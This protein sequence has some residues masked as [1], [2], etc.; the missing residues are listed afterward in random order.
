MAHFLGFNNSSIRKKELIRVRIM[1]FLLVSLLIIGLS[2][3]GLANPAFA[4][5]A[6][7]GEPVTRASIV[8]SKKHKYGTLTVP[9][10]GIYNNKIVR[11]RGTPDDGPG[12]VIQDKGITSAPYGAWGGVEVGQVGNF[13]LAG[14]R[15]SHGSLMRKV[16]KLKPGDKIIVNRGGENFTYIVAYKFVVNWKSKRSQ[17]SQLQPVPGK[18][19]V[20]A[21]R[22]AI[23]L[24]TC[25][26]PEDRAKGN[27]WRDKQGNPQHRMDVVGFLETKTP[28]IVG[29][30][31][32]TG[33]TTTSATLN[34]SVNPNAGSTDVKFTYST[35]PS[36]GAATSVTV[37]TNP[38]NLTGV[39]TR[40]VTASINGLLPATTYYVRVSASNS[41]GTKQ[42]EVITFATPA[43]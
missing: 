23:V 21:T 4:G 15:S 13:M 6:G 26:T 28:S 20:K 3:V 8:K 5:D 42:G 22:P 43:V 16:P 35:D 31:T 30:S 29:E 1:K 33:V 38:A 36:L 40:K 37:P 17:R 39:S 34:A 14:H 12:T 18:F 19:G 24:T 7:P 9:K 25:M 32:A 41:A 10:A 27:Y 2:A 11:Y